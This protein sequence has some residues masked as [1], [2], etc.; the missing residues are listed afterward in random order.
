MR[1][2]W[3]S[4]KEIVALWE[5]LFAKH[6]FLTFAG[7]ITIQALI[8]TVS[9][10]LLALGLLGATGDR[11]LWNRTIGPAIKGRVIP[12]VYRGFDAVVQHVFATS[13]I[14]LIVFATALAIWKISGVVRG[15]SDDFFVALVMEADGNYGKGRYL[16][17]RDVWKLREALQ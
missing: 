16:L 17:K 7:A 13:S 8:A 9:F 5:E 11:E 14:G 10:I 15:V 3:Q 1:S 4:F 2:R 6:R 12:E